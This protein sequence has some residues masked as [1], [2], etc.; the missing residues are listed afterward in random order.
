MVCDS[1]DETT[2]IHEDDSPVAQDGG[3]PDP[4]EV[5]RE[6]IQLR[7]GGNVT[8]LAR[9][10]AGPDATK[11]ER[12]KWRNYVNRWKRPKGAPNQHDPADEHLELLAQA[13]GEPLCL[14]RLLYQHADREDQLRQSA[15]Q[16]ARALGLQLPEA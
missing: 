4:G 8:A 15:L 11:L 12:D 16:L 10:L 13:L 1:L 7:F 5:L 2:P 14:L 6:L 3:S 9:V